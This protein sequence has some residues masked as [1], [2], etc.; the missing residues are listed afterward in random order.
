VVKASYEAVARMTQSPP[1][2]TVKAFENGDRMNAEAGFLKP[3]DR[4][5]SYDGLFT[6]EFLK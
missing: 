6:N 2:I 4:V 1:A 3:E 5:Q